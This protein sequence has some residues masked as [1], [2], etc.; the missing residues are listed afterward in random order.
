M[1]IV[2]FDPTKMNESEFPYF[3]KAGDWGPGCDHESDC[4][5]TSYE[6][7]AAQDP[8][9]DIQTDGNPEMNTRGAA[10]RG[11]YV[12]FGIQCSRQGGQNINEDWWVMQ[13]RA[14][15]VLTALGVHVEDDGTHDTDHVLGLKCI[16]HTGDP[17]ESKKTPGRF[18]STI[19]SL[20]GVG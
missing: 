5:I 17:S 14:L 16:V 11:P 3:D 6:W 18:F 10:Y 2:Q 7:P 9:F 15:K 13:N 4:E 19:R 1:A 20:Q 12:R 8:P